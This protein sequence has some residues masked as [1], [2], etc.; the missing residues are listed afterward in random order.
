MS[1]FSSWKRGFSDLVASAIAD[2]SGGIILVIS[3]KW[4]LKGETLYFIPVNSL[5]LRPHEVR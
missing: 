5:P 2:H 1:C 4:G 3:W